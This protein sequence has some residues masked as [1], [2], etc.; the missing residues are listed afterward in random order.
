MA[1]YTLLVEVDSE[2]QAALLSLDMEG[3]PHVVDVSPHGEGGTCCCKNC[4]WDGRHA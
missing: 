2:E 4:P 3:V 1:T